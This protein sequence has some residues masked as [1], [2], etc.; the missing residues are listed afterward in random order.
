MKAI[1]LNIVKLV[2]PS[3][4]ASMFVSLNFTNNVKDIDASGLGNPIILPGSIEETGNETYK[5][6]G[7]IEVRENAKNYKISMY[8]SNQIM[9]TPYLVSKHD[10]D[11]YN[12]IDKGRCCGY[13]KEEN[14]SI[15]IGEELSATIGVSIGAEA[16]GG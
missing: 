7:Q 14:T 11:Y 13:E 16:F 15:S 9:P 6:L 4:L 2:L 3:F 8:E 12:G 1:R 5:M 10:G